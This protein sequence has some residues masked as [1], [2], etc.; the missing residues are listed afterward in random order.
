MSI[1]L[2][3][4]QLDPIKKLKISGAMR[5]QAASARH[6]AGETV[7]DCLTCCSKTGDSIS[8]VPKTATVMLNIILCKDADGKKAHHKRSCYSAGTM[9]GWES[10]LEPPRL[11]AACLSTRCCSETAATNSRLCRMMAAEF[12][13]G[14][15]TTWFKSQ[16]WTQV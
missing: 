8:S 6:N 10:S 11:Q 15:H 16:M 7:L 3:S 9:T 1:G 4:S 14:P 2:T 12:L 5:V 13:K